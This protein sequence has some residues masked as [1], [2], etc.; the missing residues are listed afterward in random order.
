MRIPKTKPPQRSGVVTLILFF[1]TTAAALALAWEFDFGAPVT[2]AAIIVGV[3]ALYLGWQGL[4]D[5]DDT[6]LATMADKLADKINYQWS[7]EYAV[8]RLNDRDPL[9]V[10]WVPADPDLV[11]D[12]P[13]L[14]RLARGVAWPPVPP[15][16]TWAAGPAGLAGDDN[17]LADVLARVPTGRLIVL[18]GVGR[19]IGT[20]AGATV[21]GESETVLA[22]L[23]N[24][25]I[26]KLLVFTLIV[27]VI[28][29]FPQGLFTMQRR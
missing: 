19:L 21:I 2:V 12:W 14:T 17:K 25:V 16:G 7:R 5:R 9:S 8:R 24:N 4:G 29:V 13:S 23:Y 6:S 1:G 22:F 26:A 10:S 27:M 20:V 3:P 28:R 18:G 15:K 11:D